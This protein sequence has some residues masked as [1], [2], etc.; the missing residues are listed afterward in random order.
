[1]FGFIAA[2][3]GL[4][5]L[6]VNSVLLEAPRE[7][8]GKFFEKKEYH[9]LTYMINCMMCTGFWIGFFTS[10]F[11]TTNLNPIFCGA[12][13]SLFSHMYSEFIDYLTVSKV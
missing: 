13:S 9:M 12:I 3:V 10:F 7:Y 11:F 1:M 4:T 8:L 2:S 6:I 5:N